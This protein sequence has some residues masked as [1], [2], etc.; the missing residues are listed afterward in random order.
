MKLKLLPL[1]ILGIYY[2]NTSQNLQNLSQSACKI[3]EDVHKK[4]S[5]TKTIAIVNFEKGFEKSEIDNLIKCL[6][7]EVTVV[8]IDA[9]SYNLNMKTIH[10]VDYVIII[11]DE[12]DR[13]KLV[14]K[15]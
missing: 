12:F 13:T 5:W 1:I 9:M 10:N 8:M 2:A 11:V 3:V 15:I 6:P 14:R 4:E 7:A